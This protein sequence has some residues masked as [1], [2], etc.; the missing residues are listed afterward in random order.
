MD[1][2]ATVDW[3]SLTHAYGS[4]EDI[5]DQL[6]ALASA[7]PSTRARA[8]EELDSRVCHQ[9][10]RFEAS[11]HVAPFLVDLASDPTTP[12]RPGVLRLLAALAIG[13]DRWWLPATY[14]VA[15]VRRDVGR[16]AGLTLEG[17]QREL[18]DWVAG[19]PT[20]RIRAARAADAETREVTEERDAEKW[21]L[22]A[23]DAVR[24]GVGVYR[25]ALDCGDP[26]VR[27]WAAYLLGWFPEE[28]DASLPPLVRRLEVEPDPSVAATTAIATGLVAPAAD[29]ATWRAL[30]GRLR[31]QQHVERWAAAIALALMD[32]SPDRGVVEALYRCLRHA[33]PLLL[34]RVPYLEGDLPG[35]AALALADLEAAAAP[36]RLDVLA[37]R[38]VG[39]PASRPADAMV[40]ALLTAAFP[41]GFAP[42]GAAFEEL[43]PGQRKAVRALATAPGIWAFYDV[44]VLVGECG[45]PDDQQS[46]R[47]YAGA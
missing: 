18:D 27:L 33:E 42:E 6:R 7:D 38:L 19:A 31:A 10:S 39:W 17:L 34:H 43:T 2:L 47:A 9:G 37:D 4:A 28:R 29:A 41:D 45:L 14:P 20:G 46:L 1:H 22:A 8:H 36:E 16:K 5:P 24:R 44:R 30:V 32:Q 3:G 13:F 15:E 21:A 26:E 11:E 23:Y 25:E 35:L 40:S 12:D